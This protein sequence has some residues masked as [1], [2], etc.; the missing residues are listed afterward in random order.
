MFRH[1]CS[2]N[3]RQW[4]GIRARGSCRVVHHG[5]CFFGV[6]NTALAP[7]VNC[8]CDLTEE[9]KEAHEAFQAE[10]SPAVYRGADGCKVVFPDNQAWGP[11]KI[12]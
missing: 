5:W 10:I 3:G 6:M 12:P 11:G 1:S 8:Q 4:A 9:E 2:P 7:L